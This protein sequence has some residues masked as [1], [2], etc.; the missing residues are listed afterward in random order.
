MGGNQSI[1]SHDEAAFGQTINT[2]SG[3]K[4]LGSVPVRMPAGNDVATHAV[5]RIKLLK[6]KERSVTLQI[7]MHT[8]CIIDTKTTDVLKRTAISDVS[9]VTQ[10]EDDQSIVS[11]FEN[12]K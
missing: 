7:T 3:V 6:S 11:F 2:F 5:D 1:R 10:Q 4:Y 9:F 12:C 8:I